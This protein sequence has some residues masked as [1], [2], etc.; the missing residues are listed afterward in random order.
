MPVSKAQQKAVS[1]YMKTNYDEL[2]VRVPK[3]RKIKIQ[4]AADSAG[5]SLNG[6]IIKAVDER[7]ARDNLSERQD[8]KEGGG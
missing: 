3:G 7:I 5:E 6:Y 2:K 8:K 4:G 1:K